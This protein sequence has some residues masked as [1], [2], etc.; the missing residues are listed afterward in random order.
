MASYLPCKKNNAAGYV[1]YVSLVSQ[2]NTK[3]LQANPTLAAGDV[4]ISID[5]G[6]PANLGTLPAVDA[7]FTK[8]VKVTLSQAETNGDNL[9]IVFSDAAGDEWCDLTV[10]IQTGA[11]TFDE[12]D[13]VVD[14]AAADVVNIDGAVMRGTDSAAL[15]SVC[16]EARL[17][18]L[19]SA[20]IPADID[21]LK[22]QVGTAG[23]GL[24]NLGGMS[25]TMKGQVNT[26]CDTALSDVDLDHLIQVSAEAEE[27]TDGSYLDQVMHKN[28]S[29]TFDAATDSLEAVRDRGDAAWAG[30]PEACSGTFTVQVADT[31]FNL[32][33]TLGTLWA[34]D[35]DVPPQNMI[36]CM[37]DT[38]AGT[39]ETRRITDYEVL[40]GPI[41]RVT[42]DRNLNFPGEDG[43]D[44]W[45]IYR[46]AYAPVGAASITES[47]KNDIVDKI[48]EEPDA[49]HMTQGT[50]GLK[51]H[52][53]GKGRY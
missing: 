35:D 18:E 23:A 2:A 15:A 37:Q 24:T 45:V 10:S 20:N 8:R 13:A 28:A 40:A 36:I 49:D 52:H 50:K 21:T 29:Q 4:K 26:E 1:F 27:P 31:V 32:T 46:S 16:T 30:T 22:T 5:D 3:I 39:Y 19:A 7:D 42:L 48:F 38:S 34:S 17:A 51:I 44:T 6:A 9:T 25:A 41:Y 14:T 33:A 43:V 47:D 53:A 11:Q 12:T